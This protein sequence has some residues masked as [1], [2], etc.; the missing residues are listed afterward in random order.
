MAG[1]VDRPLSYAARLDTR[2]LD[3]VRR[4]VI[5]A[6][7]LPDLATAR[8]YGERI[9]YPESRTGNSG[10]YYIDRDGT[11]E[12]WVPPDRIAHHVAGGNADSIGIELVNRGRWPDWYHSQRQRWS[13]EYTDAQIDALIELL[14][15]L[16]RTLPSLTT[17][18]G[19]AELDRRRVP[20]SD[21][22]DRSVR[23]KV[24]PGPYFPWERV[25][26]ATGLKRA[27]AAE[28]P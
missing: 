4:V 13:E 22:P 21:D 23:R 24:D 3:A 9:R 19:H 18:A 25:L 8:E 17:I 26:A 2:P 27:S 1:I 6:T 20:A 7:E 12:R 5:H 10:H 28:A 16:R 11:V 14:A 15:A